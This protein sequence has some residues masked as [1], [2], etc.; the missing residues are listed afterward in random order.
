MSIT[1]ISAAM[2]MLRAKPSHPRNVG[3]E[4]GKLECLELVVLSSVKLII[5]VSQKKTTEPG[6]VDDLI[7]F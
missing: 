1:S 3:S 5:V 4:L 2:Q 6:T 7:I